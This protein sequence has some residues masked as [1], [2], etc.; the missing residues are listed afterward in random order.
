MKRPIPDTPSKLQGSFMSGILQPTGQ[1]VVLGMIRR[2]E[3][4]PDLDQRRM[5]AQRAIG[6]LMALTAFNADGVG[7]ASFH[8][9]VFA[10]L[11]ELTEMGQ[12]ELVTCAGVAR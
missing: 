2:V 3:L 5:Q 9:L 4:T 6:A 10:R 12:V 7:S 11:A 8:K 1:E